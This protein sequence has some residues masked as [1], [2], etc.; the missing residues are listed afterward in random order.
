MS[1]SIFSLIPK[2]KLWNMLYSFHICMGISV[3]LLDENC[4][5]LIYHG[6]ESLFCNTFSKEVENIENCMSVYLRATKMS[7]EFGGAYIFSCSA[8]LSNMIF[9]IIVKKKL[10]ASV[11]VGPFLFDSPDS[12]D[13]GDY[14]KK[15][16]F[17]LNTVDVLNEFANILPIITPSMTNHISNL[18]GFLVGGLIVNSSAEIAKNQEKLYQQSRIN[19]AIQTYKL[20]ENTNSSEYPFQQEKELILRIKTGDSDGA[21]KILNEF[22]GYVFFSE[23]NGLDAVKLRSVELASV[24]SRA[25]IDS[26]ASP[27]FVLSVNK[28]YQKALPLYKDIDTVCYELQNVLDA[29]IDSL[30]YKT[31]NE[32]NIHIHKAMAMIRADYHKK[33]TLEEVAEFVHLSPAY[34][35]SIFKKVT[36]ISFVQYLNNVRVEE[37]KYLLLNTDYSITDIAFSV[38]FEDQSYFCRV[39]RKVIGISPGQYKKMSGNVMN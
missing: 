1:N 19:E 32:N 31:K 20:I 21:R 37:S 7:A 24:L 17:N 13:I 29:F 30:F 38:G 34:F 5:E 14:Q 9:P 8:G 35:S 23:G 16:G 4:G 27:E 28:K 6:K 22:L 10:I 2:E 15:F 26:G 33:I 36:N 18:L 3:K 11:L 25:T 12:L 39:F